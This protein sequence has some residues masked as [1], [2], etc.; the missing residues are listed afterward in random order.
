MSSEMNIVLSCREADES[1]LREVCDSFLGPPTGMAEVTV[2][3]SQNPEWDPYVL[4]RFLLIHDHLRSYLQFNLQQKMIT[5]LISHCAWDFCH[6]KS[7][8]Q[9]I[10]ISFNSC[11]I[12]LMS[13]LCWAWVHEHEYPHYLRWFNYHLHIWQKHFYAMLII[14]NWNH[15]SNKGFGVS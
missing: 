3:D 1:R 8:V 7:Y 9:L 11:L 15:R 10:P 14:W 12:D 5:Y 4:V 2:V 6:L 13:G